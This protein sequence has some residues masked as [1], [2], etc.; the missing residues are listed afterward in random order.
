MKITNVT[1][2]V[3]GI[4][5]TDLMPDQSMEISAMDAAIP[6]ISVLINMGLLTLDNSAELKKAMESAAMQEARKQ[7]MEELR[8]AGKLKDEEEAPG[9]GEAEADCDEKQPPKRKGRQPKIPEVSAE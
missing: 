3:I 6:S 9:S 2:K 1:A 5:G 7:V 4:L 8:V